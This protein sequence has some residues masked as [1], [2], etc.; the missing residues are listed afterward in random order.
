MGKETD[1]QVQEEQRFPK[2]NTKK[3]KPR[4]IIIKMAKNKDKE[5]IL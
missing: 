1:I 5:I 4:Y 3:T 2:I